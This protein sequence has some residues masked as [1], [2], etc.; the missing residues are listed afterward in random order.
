TA[1][2]ARSARRKARATAWYSVRQFAPT[3]WQTTCC[4]RCATWPAPPMAPGVCAGTLPAPPPQPHQL[5]AQRGLGDRFAQLT[6]R[7]VQERQRL[8]CLEEA[9]QLWTTR[10]PT[11]AAAP[12]QAV[13]PPR[14]GRSSDPRD[15]AQSAQHGPASSPLRI[16]R[17][18]GRPP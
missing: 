6:V 13:V 16:A 4:T 11:T 15:E 17:T 9:A 5:R 2:L 14:R 18:A 1:L 7:T 10:D 8:R 3:S 12:G